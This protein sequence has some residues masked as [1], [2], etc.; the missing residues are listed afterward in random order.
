MGCIESP[1]NYGLDI[2]AKLIWDGNYRLGIDSIGKHG[3]ERIWAGYRF[4]S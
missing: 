2:I 1:D 4:V 3:R